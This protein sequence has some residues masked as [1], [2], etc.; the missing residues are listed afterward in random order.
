MTHPMFKSMG[1][2]KSVIF[3]GRSSMGS[4]VYDLVFAN[5]EVVMSA[6][7]DAQGRNAGGILAPPGAN[8]PG[9]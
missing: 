1:E 4:D 8:I 6:S 2:L 7:L 3:R 5:G 9:L